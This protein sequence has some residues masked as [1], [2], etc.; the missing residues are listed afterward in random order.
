T[1]L[2]RYNRERGN[3]HVDKAICEMKKLMR[4]IQ[5]SIPLASMM[6]YEGM[7]AK[8]YF[9]SLGELVDENFSFQNRS[10]QPPLDPFNSLLSF[11]YTLLMYDVYTAIC[12]ERLHPYLGFMHV[13]KQGHPALASDLMEEWRAIIVDSLVMALVQGH[14]IFPEDFDVDID[15]GGVYLKNEKRKFFIE[16]YEKRMLRLNKYGDYQ[17]TF[18]ELME[19]QVRLYAKCLRENDG[20]LYKGIRIR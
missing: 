7:A 5:P 12:N 11:G 20:T 6:G 19:R 8:L 18:R 10:Q 15:S 9:R 16:Q 1:L 4:K 2:R 17:C 13:L 3:E 14:E